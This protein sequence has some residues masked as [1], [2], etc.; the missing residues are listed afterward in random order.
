MFKSS[1]SIYLGNEAEHLYVDFVSDERFFMIVEVKSDID[2]EEIKALLTN[3]KESIEAKN[4]NSLQALTDLVDEKVSPWMSGNAFSLAAALMSDEVM[5]LMTRGTG[6]VYVVRSGK[7]SKLLNGSSS[8]SGYIKHN[9]FFVL[10]VPDFSQKVGEKKLAHILTG[11]DPQSALELLTPELKSKEDI[12]MIAIFIQCEK[13]L[14]ESTETYADEAEETVDGQQPQIQPPARSK[15]QDFRTWLEHLKTNRKSKKATFI[16]VLI[17]I[18]IFIWS[19]IL[20]NQRREKKN[21]L[22][23]V[24][25]QEKLIN[26][27]LNQ[28]EE[29]SGTNIRKAVALVDQAQSLYDQIVLEG[30]NKKISDVEKVSEIKKRIDTK[31]KAIKKSEQG[32]YE[33]FYDF[34]LIESGTR[35][36]D[37]FLDG[38]DLAILDK[39][40]GMIYIL[41]LEKK[42]VSSIKSSNA[43]AASQVALYQNE[44]YLFSQ[45]KGI[46]KI[47]DQKKEETVISKDD[48][49]GSIKDFWIYNGNIYLLDTEKDEIYK[50]L[51]AE[52][53]YSNKSS[54]FKSGQSADLALAEGMTIDAS[55]YIALGGKVLKYGSGARNDFK[56]NLPDDRLVF[57]SIFT[58]SSLDN[59]YLSDKENGTVVVVDK[60]GIFKEQI[61]ASVA[62][63]TI[64]IIVRENNEIL[65]VTKDKMY[66]ILK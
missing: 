7:G 38:D 54:Y 24:D 52:N 26:E 41:S 48:E 45:A 8:S 36:D 66:K 43:R 30:E 25:R 4:V 34:S 65:L 18:V 27:K 63:Q 21:Y 46:I 29:S 59:V 47:T 31:E 2:K 51:V 12:G 33:E 44:P 39:E 3:I 28:A 58:S 56:M 11:K 53:G 16:I 1:Y 6:E 42:S 5:Y 17:L 20:G 37:V 23:Y 32:K 49:W 62:R 14:A 57:N 9:D 10:T 61:S 50:Y 40:K 35:S 13:Y 15:M 64:N 60:D 22:T 19:V 55:V